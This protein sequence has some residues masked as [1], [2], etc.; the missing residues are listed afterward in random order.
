MIRNLQL[1]NFT[2]FEQADLQFSPGLNV[3]IGE[4]G[5]GKTHLLKLGYLFS[6]AWPRL[7]KEPNVAK[8]H[9]ENYF[10]LHLKQLFKP[11]K[12][13]SLANSESDG[14]SLVFGRCIPFQSLQ[15]S[16]YLDEV[17]WKFSFSRL[18]KENIGI[19]SFCI[20]L[21]DDDSCGKAVYLPAKEM[22]SF[23]EGFLAL[24]TKREIAMDETYHD[25]ALNLSMPKLK[26]IPEFL[27]DA[28]QDL[29]E[30]I[31]GALE[32]DGGKF[33]LVANGK[34]R[35]EITLVAEGIRKL[36]TLRHLIEN[37]SLERG[38]TLFWDEPE[39]NL[40]PKLIKDVAAALLFLCK[41]GIQ[42]VV[43]TH[44]LFL[45]REL[46][47]LAAQED[48]K[49]L[50][51]RYFALEKTSSGIQ[52]HQGDTVDEIDPLVLLDEDLEQSD[53]FMSIGNEQ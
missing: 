21:K 14:K 6:N 39:S 5:T 27:V 34:K 25:L 26:N 48:Y 1:R 37:G 36:A 51:Q 29:A 2:A 3:I 45:L 53:R 50:P 49:S 24:Y 10:S 35:R 23:F 22:L 18:A 47:I 7:A 43:A 32:L 30:D 19:E 16:S 20:D 42:V 9:I 40:N 13:G 15:D 28:L 38:D 17:D 44:S 33:Y 4:N 11:D 52:V 12:I 46:E 8:K 31:G 41:N